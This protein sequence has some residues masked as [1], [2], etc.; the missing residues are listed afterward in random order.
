MTETNNFKR[1][2]KIVSQQLGI[3]LEKVTPNTNFIKLGA[4][5][6]DIIEI[7]MTIEYEFDIYIEDSYASKITTVQDALNYIENNMEQN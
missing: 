5:S 4:D 2:R 3:E 6:L 1:I 7:V